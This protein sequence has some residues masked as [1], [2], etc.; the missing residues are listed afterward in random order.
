[1]GDEDFTGAAPLFLENRGFATAQLVSPD[2]MRNAQQASE[3]S[4]PGEPY[5]SY[6][7]Y[8]DGW[9]KFLFFVYVLLMV[10]LV[11][12]SEWEALEIRRKAIMARTQ[13]ERQK[14]IEDVT[15]RQAPLEQEQRTLSRKIN[16]LREK[17]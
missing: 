4:A 5:V 3:G 16:E 17:L 1:M 14:L 9:V 6:H 2:Q 13:E 15:K 7:T 10:G 12:K 11:L 8:L